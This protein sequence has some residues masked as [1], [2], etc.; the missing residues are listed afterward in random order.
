M[1]SYSD[2]VDQSGSY[3]YGACGEKIVTFD[4]G[5]PSFIAISADGTDPINNDLTIVYSEAGATS[6]DVELT[7][8][9][10]FQVSSKEYGPTH[11][12]NLADSF[13]IRI[14][15]PS[16]VYE[17]TYSKTLYTDLL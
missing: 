2:S 1:S 15:C 11:I 5:A 8:T 13:T 12:P 16:E 7:H 9:I 6:S 3:H 10:S 4:A 14:V 17:S